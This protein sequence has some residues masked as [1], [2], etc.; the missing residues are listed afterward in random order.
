MLDQSEIVQHSIV[1]YIPVMQN[2]TT[3]LQT[4]QGFMEIIENWSIWNWLIAAVITGTA[5]MLTRLIIQLLSFKK[6]IAKARLLSAD[7]IKLYQVDENI[8]PFSFGNSIFINHRLHA[9]EELKEIIRHEFVHVK[10]RHTVDIIWSEILVILNWYNPFA[11]LIRN[12]IRQNLEFIA[13]NKVVQ[14]GMDKTQYQYL[15]LKVIGNNHFSITNKFNFSSLKKRIA[16]MN[17]IKTAKVHLLKFMFILPLLAV[18]LVSFRDKIL[19]DDKAMMQYGGI[20]IDINTKEPLKGVKIKD[21]IS[22]KETA[23]DEQGYFML[24]FDKAKLSAIKFIISK[25]NYIDGSIDYNFA[26]R[27]EY[28]TRNQVA[29]FAIKQVNAKDDGKNYSSFSMHADNF[30][31][32]KYSDAKK[33]YD[34]YIKKFQGNSVDDKYTIWW[35]KNSGVA[36]SDTVPKLLELKLVQLSEVKV[37]KPLEIKL[38]DLTID[39]IPK[40]LELK[41]TK[42]QDTLKALLLKLDGVQISDD[43][44]I[45]SHGKQVDKIIVDGKPADG[46]YNLQLKDVEVENQWNPQPTANEK[47]FLKRHPK[48]EKITWAYITSSSNNDLIGKSGDAI[49]QLH[50]KNGNWDMYNI[51]RKADVEKFKKNYGEAPPIAPP[52]PAS[53]RPG[54]IGVGVEKPVTKNITLSGNTKSLYDFNGINDPLFIIDGKKVTDIELKDID[55][56]TIESVDILKDAKA[57][58]EYGSEARNGVI[59]IELKKAKEKAKN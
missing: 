50:F 30:Q 20:V 38:A 24:E 36:N 15:L 55:P 18:V 26:A 14:S 56:D 31:S 44:S 6:I 47:D 19:P 4:K 3:V 33:M 12:A 58:Q 34:D 11:W 16:M 1:S 5:F 49:M 59:R 35:T 9:D 17:K 13:D 2:L 57:T 10:Q 39:T 29:L 37:E 28:E 32:V 42:Q 48:I 54:V 45:K 51:S 8:I 21:G 41:L 40:A 53:K 22:G 52:P 7:D 27:S 46:I 43:G 23:T 25:D